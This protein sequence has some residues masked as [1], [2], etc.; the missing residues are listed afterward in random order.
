MN[1]EKERLKKELDG[2]FGKAPIAGRIPRMMDLCEQILVIDP[3]DR[4][5]YSTYNVYGR[6]LER[7]AFPFYRSLFERYPGS[8]TVLNGFFERYEKWLNYEIDHGRISGDEII[9]ILPKEAKIYVEFA[10]RINRHLMFFDEPEDD[11]VNPEYFLVKALEFDPEYAP[12]HLWLGIIGKDARRL[13]HLETYSALMQGGTV[14]LF[15]GNEYMKNG[16]YDMGLTQYTHLPF[17]ELLGY[18]GKIPLSHFSMA[19]AE[20]WCLLTK[21]KNEGNIHRD[22]S[23]L[24]EMFENFSAPCVLEAARKKYGLDVNVA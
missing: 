1:T 10:S 24:Q 7:R 14:R 16:R 18:I 2:L 9:G 21:A 6:D 15:L 17:H 3:D 13:E 12:A 19:C 20:A 11:Y 23:G 8:M 22:I 4:D 5:V